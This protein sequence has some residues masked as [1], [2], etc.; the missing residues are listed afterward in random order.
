MAV[1]DQAS[2]HISQ[3]RAIRVIFW[4]WFEQNR[5]LVVFEISVLRVFRRSVKVGDLRSLFVLLFGEP[6]RDPSVAA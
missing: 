1:L 4:L 2:L 3:D 5:E 6:A